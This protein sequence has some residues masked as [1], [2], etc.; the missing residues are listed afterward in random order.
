[1][2]D[3]AAQFTRD[4]FAADALAAEEK[5]RALSV[6]SAHTALR[7]A[8]SVGEA[9]VSSTSTSNALTSTSASSSIELISHHLASLTAALRNE[10]R[11]ALPAHISA[12]G[13]FAVVQD[14]ADGAI[15]DDAS[16][17]LSPSSATVSSPSPSSSSAPAMSEFL[18]S[19]DSND[20]S[21]DASHGSSPRPPKH[22]R[23]TNPS[24]SGNGNNNGHG[25]A[26]A[27]AIGSEALI[28][29][30]SGSAALWDDVRRATCALAANEEMVPL[31]GSALV[32]LH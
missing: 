6:P 15:H 4:S 8:P 27:S 22:N 18:H 32:Q 20:E 3:L 28:E 30:G 12:S 31:L 17:S 5:E 7:S 9:R 21:G 10:E 13:V 26:S 11:H 24:A 29:S 1:M 14:G 19:V 25:N 16:S 23:G 2:L